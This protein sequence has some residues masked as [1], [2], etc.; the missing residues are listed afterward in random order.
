MDIRHIDGTTGLGRNETGQYLQIIETHGSVPT[1]R[2][3]DFSD[4]PQYEAASRQVYDA[5]EKAIAS[6]NNGRTG[7]EPATAGEGAFKST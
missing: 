1:K 6:S 3:F 7:A 5:I 2:M 4:V